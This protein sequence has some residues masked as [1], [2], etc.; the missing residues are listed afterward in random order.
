MTSQ[1]LLN[2]HWLDPK[3]ISD[4]LSIT[5]WTQMTS[6]TFSMIM[7]RTERLHNFL[8]FHGLD[9]MTS[10]LPQLSWAGPNDFTTSSIIM[11]WTK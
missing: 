5:A 11:G 3:N 9:Q 2:D 4:Y 1:N 8:N 7:S 6:L 10:Q